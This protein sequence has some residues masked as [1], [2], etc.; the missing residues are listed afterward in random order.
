MAWRIALLGVAAILASAFHLAE[1]SA[2][3]KEA[4]PAKGDRLGKPVAVEVDG[5]PLA[6]AGS[7]FVGD[8]DGDGLPDLLMGYG[9]D[10][11]LQIYRNIGTRTAPRLTGPQWFD[12]LVPT[13][14]VPK[15]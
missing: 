15:G 7:P 14:R 1:Q 11:R 4:A 8:F 6:A 2:D 12:E 10:G 3:R 5:K 9:R 13:G